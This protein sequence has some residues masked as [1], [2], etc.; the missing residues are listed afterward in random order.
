MTLISGWFRSWVLLSLLP[1]VFVAACGGSSKGEGASK[2]DNPKYFFGTMTAMDIDIAY[3]TGA[4]PFASSSWTLLKANLE[5]LFRERPLKPVISLPTSSDQMTNIPSQSKTKWSLFDILDLEKTYRSRKSEGTTGRFWVVFLK[6]YLEKDDVPNT[7]V[8]G[9]SITGTTVIAMFKDVIES[10]GVRANGPV[11][12][13]VQ[14]ST[15]IHEIGHALGLVG[16]GVT[17]QSSHL[18]AAHGAHCKNPDCVMY[19]TNEG[20]DAL[21]RFREQLRETDDPVIFGAECLQDTKLFNP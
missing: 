9:V 10:T 18:D 19:W 6:G 5:A 4:E 17:L 7:S 3:E 8:I 16:N 20:R 1:L 11:P 21:E 2:I 15:I 13:F 12:K 14:Q